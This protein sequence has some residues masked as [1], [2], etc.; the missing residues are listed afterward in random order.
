[1]ECKMKCKVL[2]YDSKGKC[3]SWIDGEVTRMVDGDVN[4]NFLRYEVKTNQGTYTP[5]HP[6]C[7]RLEENI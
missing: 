1:M 5:C 4:E 7:V 3:S 6:D 2:V